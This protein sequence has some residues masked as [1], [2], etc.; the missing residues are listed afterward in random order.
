MEYTS[1][2]KLRNKYPE[3]ISTN[4]NYSGGGGSIVYTGK[5]KYKNKINFSSPTPSVTA[6]AGTSFKF[7]VQIGG[8]LYTSPAY[9][10]LLN[11]AK[12]ENNPYFQVSTSPI[13]QVDLQEAIKQEF[14]GGE[15]KQS[16][17]ESYAEVEIT[18]NI[19]TGDTITKVIQHID[20]LVSDQREGLRD[21]KEGGNRTYGNYIL[22]TTEY[23]I[24][25]DSGLGF[26]ETE[27][28]E[29]G[30]PTNTLETQGVSVPETSTP[31]IA[32]V[33]EKQI[34][35]PPSTFFGNNNPT[36]VN[37]EDL[38]ENSET[39]FIDN[40][41]NDSPIIQTLRERIRDKRKKLR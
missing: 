7:I 6:V 23:D 3:E 16:V 25:N 18:E 40:A 26:E 2:D 4:K 10:S 32:L 8:G 29:G 33:E 21:I 27:K 22:K 9:L 38:S 15:K 24:E 34:I 20:W 14:L 35:T 17:E 11:Q 28:I 13:V 19:T 30:S 37:N 39:M 12:A 36:L 31:K 41:S 1:L 5:P